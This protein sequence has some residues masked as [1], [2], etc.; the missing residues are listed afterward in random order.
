MYEVLGSG[1]MVV[2][3]QASIQVL[4]RNQHEKDSVYFIAERPGSPGLPH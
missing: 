4:M 1:Y 2:W 3:M